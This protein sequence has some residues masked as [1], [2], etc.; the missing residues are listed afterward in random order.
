MTATNGT[1]SKTIL[2]PVD[3]SPAS[4]R[5]LVHAAERHAH[6]AELIVLHVGSPD[7][8][9]PGLL[10]KEQLHH[11]SRYSDMLSAYR[12]NV[13]FSVEYGSPADI[14]IDQAGRHD[15]E[16]IVLASH[17]SNNI[18]RLLV[19]S[20]TE[21]VMRRAGCPVL[22]LKS[23]AVAGAGIAPAGAAVLSTTND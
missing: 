3:F 23:P 21:A 18:S 17:G 15:A 7:A 19:G 10:L 6:D 4:E 12:C 13:R 14:I 20:T 22:V 16:L 5:A 2:C 8:G 1:A 9:D 11:F